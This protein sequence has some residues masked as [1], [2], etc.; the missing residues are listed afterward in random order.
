[1]KLIL[2]FCVKAQKIKQSL[3]FLF[4]QVVQNL[5]GMGFAVVPFGQRFKDMPPLT[6]ELMKL[7]LEERIYSILE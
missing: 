7:V 3:M 5:E 2:I 1:M 6:K 4:I